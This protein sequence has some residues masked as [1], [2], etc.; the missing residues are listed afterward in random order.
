MLSRC[1][2]GTA[3]LPFRTDP[4]Y[5]SVLVLAFALLFG[6]SLLSTDSGAQE[7][8]K[9]IRGYKVHREQI[10]V[11]SGIEREG[12]NGQ[13]RV[14]AGDPSLVDISLLGVTFS[15]P[16]EAMIPDRSGK[17]DL[18]AFHDLRVNGIQVEIEEYSAKFS[19]RKN[20]LIALPE[21]ARIFL[22]TVGIIQA[23]WNEMRDSKG[24]W[25]ITGR[26][27]V[28]GRFRSY[29]FYHKRVV[30]IDLDLK[31]RNPVSR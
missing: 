3:R 16:V 27:F 8:P 17:V 1:Q 13:A 24:E 9:T 21:P 30:P 31:I 28:F 23:A 2:P 18:L 12:E 5:V 25:T 11:S 4:K 7:L 20:E 15:L 14:H 10:T 22:P 6:M 26:V 19:F 29:G